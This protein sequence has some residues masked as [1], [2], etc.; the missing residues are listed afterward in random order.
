V[1]QI[2]CLTTSTSITRRSNC[3][4]EHSEVQP[5]QELIPEGFY[6]EDADLIG[7]SAELTDDIHCDV[8]PEGTTTLLK[9]IDWLGKEDL[10]EIRNTREASAD[11]TMQQ[12]KE[13]QTYHSRK[14][15]VIQLQRVPRS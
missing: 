14:A 7:N 1:P 9:T 15:K 10:S 8:R 2:S 11:Q 6:R 13:A 5:S 3:I 12:A 4:E